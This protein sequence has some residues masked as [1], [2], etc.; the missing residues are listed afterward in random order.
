MYGYI[1]IY[2]QKHVGTYVIHFWLSG[3]Q[4]GNAGT[5]TTDHKS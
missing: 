3:C 1:Y 5:L 2:T 4:K